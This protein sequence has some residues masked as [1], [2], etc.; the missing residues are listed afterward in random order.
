MDAPTISMRLLRI[1]DGATTTEA[2]GAD[3]RIESAKPG[4]YRV[5][6]RIVPKHVRPY[7]G[8]QGDQYMTERPWIYS[9]PI[10]VL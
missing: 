3:L 7:L 5:E 6:V 10:R 1:A 4:V 9:N 2:E 8:D